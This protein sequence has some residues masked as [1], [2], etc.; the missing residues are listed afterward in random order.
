MG[1]AASTGKPRW[2]EGIHPTLN[3]PEAVQLVLDHDW[4][5]SRRVQQP[6][7]QALLITTPS[8]WLPR[9]RF[10]SHSL[11][12]STHMLLRLQSRGVVPCRQPPQVATAT[13]GTHA[14]FAFERVVAR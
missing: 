7:V 10:P 1:A 8:G 11:P 5:L 9:R 3:I 14:K 12:A 13:V 2:L 4:R 6:L